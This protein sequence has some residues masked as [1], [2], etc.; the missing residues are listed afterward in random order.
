MSGVQRAKRPRTTIP[1][2]HG[3]RAGDLLDR[4]FTAPGPNRVWVADF[5][6]VRT[7]AGFCYVAFIVDV[8]AQKIVAWHAATDKRTDLVLTPLRMAL[9]DRDRSPSTS[10]WSRSRRRSGPWAIPT[11][12]RLCLAVRRPDSCLRLTPRF[13][14]PCC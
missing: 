2:K 7:W 14:C 4:D 5:T 8:F 10:H 12:V 13:G 11:T 6:Y 1:A 3:Q 9:W